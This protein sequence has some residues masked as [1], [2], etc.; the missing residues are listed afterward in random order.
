VAGIEAVG[1]G[2]ARHFPYLESDTHDSPD[3][4]DEGIRDAIPPN[5]R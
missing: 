5:Y 3:E 1:A 2:L 4:G